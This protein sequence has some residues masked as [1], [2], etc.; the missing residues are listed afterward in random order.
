MIVI[1]LTLFWEKPWY[2]EKNNGGIK[3]LV[4]ATE[5]LKKQKLVIMQ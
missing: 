3:M 2:N 5:M 1:F 4:S